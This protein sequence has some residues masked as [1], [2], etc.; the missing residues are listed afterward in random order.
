MD[1]FGSGWGFFGLGV[2]DE[3]HKG[4]LFGGMGLGRSDFFGQLASGGV[5][6]SVWEGE[7]G[8]MGGVSIFLGKRGGS[9]ITGRDTWTSFNRLSPKQNLVS[10]GY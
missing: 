10:P 2:G 4:H 8:A 5:F 9:S 6:L 3:R 1:F 7:V